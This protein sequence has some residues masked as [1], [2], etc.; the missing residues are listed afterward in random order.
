MRY[1]ICG[2]KSLQPISSDSQR[3]TEIVF[4]RNTKYFKLCTK[5]HTGKIILESFEFTGEL[6]ATNIK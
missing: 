1:S 2:R 3:L 5:F 4:V 6:N